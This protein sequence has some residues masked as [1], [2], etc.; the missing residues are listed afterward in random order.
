M[1]GI[2]AVLGNT[3]A[4][5]L[6]LKSLEKILHRG[7]KPFE[8]EAGEDY[9]L[10]ANRL[11]I[12]DRENTQ[13]PVRNEEG[14]LICVFNGE[15]FN[16]SELRKSLEEQGHSLNSSCDSELLPH[17]YEEYGEQ[18]LE[19]LDSE[20]YA[21]I[22]YDQKTKSY[23]AARDPIGVKPLYWAVAGSTVYFASEIKQLVHFEQIK[24]IQ[25]VPPGHYVKDGRVVKYSTLLDKK[26]LLTVPLDEMIQRVRTLLYEA[27]RKRVQTDLPIGVFLSGGLDSTAILSIARRFHPNVTA[28]L[29]G[30]KG[31]RDPYYAEKYCKEFNVPYKFLESPSEEE[32][33]KR[34]QEI[35]YITETFEPNVVRQSAI[36]FYISKL[37]KGFRIILCG[38]GADEIF[39]GYPEF[40]GV[41]PAEIN[42]LSLEFLKDL[43]RTQLQ[44][45]DRTSMHFTEEVRVPFL[46][47]ELVAYALRIPGEY[48]VREGTTKWILRK[49]MELELPEYIC[50]RKKVVLS[51]GAGYKGNDP[52]DG[53]FS[54]FIERKM[55]DGEFERVKK[56][57]SPWNLRTKEEA[58]YFSIFRDFNFHKGTFAKKRVRANRTKSVRVC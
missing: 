22:I 37:G 44:R 52:S 9:S 36:S 45:V 4:E 21:F 35:I 14:N 12:V 30:K 24:E 32:L 31:S 27:V 56:E 39:A 41:S 20:M 2:G 51:E 28:L 3:N 47:S 58:Y 33:E 40:E 23:F 26:K 10:G 1:C 54:S 19:Y 46:D 7:L 50:W 42:T 18:M 16:Y 6:L 11:P 55:S 29:V 17:L 25:V 34:I 57:F 38:E 53:M 43:H 15:L 48:K 13:Q 49:A 5:E 8:I